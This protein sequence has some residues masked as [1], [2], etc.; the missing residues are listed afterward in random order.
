MQVHNGPDPAADASRLLAIVHEI[1]KAEKADDKAAEKAAS[2]KLRRAGESLS[3][4]EVEAALMA[5]GDNTGRIWTALVEAGW[6]PA[7]WE[8][9]VHKAHW[10]RCL[11]LAIEA[12]ADDLLV[13]EIAKHLLPSSEATRRAS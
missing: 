6:K 11:E 7:S 5:A 10:H 2:D 4:A 1:Y 3:D 12:G 9:P 8:A 13:L